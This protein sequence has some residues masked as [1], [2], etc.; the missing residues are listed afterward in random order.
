MRLAWPCTAIGALALL[1]TAHG[2]LSQ[3]SIDALALEPRPTDRLLVFAPHPDDEAL[4]A[5]GLMRRMRVSGAAVHVVLLTSGDAFSEGVKTLEDTEHLTRRDFRGYGRLREQESI[6]G[7][8]LLDVDRASVTFLGFPDDGLCLIA[9]K[10]LS[11]KKRPLKSQYTGREQPPAD[12]QLIHG[13]A[14]RG[15]DIRR[16]IESILTTFKPT[17]LVLPHPEDRHPEHCGTAIFVH[18]ALDAIAKN[19]GS[20]PAPRVL[21][22]L[23]HY[24]QWPN[25]DED[26]ASTLR[27]PADFPKNEQW[28]TLTLTR[29][30]TAIKQR[31]IGAYASQIE[32]IGRFMRAFAR[33][34]ELFLEGTATTAAECW[35]DAEHVATET[36]PDRYRRRPAP[37]R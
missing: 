37:R 25:L 30:E 1:A 3:T 16:E 32:V 22:Y 14:Y 17:L 29:A 11:A 4:A 26:P 21:H 10:Y 12:E 34:N 5:A 28:R 2:F 35:C 36:P 19:P 24:D 27:P 13:V 9:S 8:S 7:L 23:I 6:A 31:A 15:T 18:E 33:P 20:V